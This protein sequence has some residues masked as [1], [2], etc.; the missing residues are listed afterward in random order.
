MKFLPL[1]ATLLLAISCN[2]KE[3]FYAVSQP[4][5]ATSAVN[6]PDDAPLIPPKNATV[7]GVCKIETAPNY[8]A[9]DKDGAVIL[10]PD[11][12]LCEKKVCMKE[13]NDTPF[14][15]VNP[16]KVVFGCQTLQS[17]KE[18]E[19]TLGWAADDASTVYIDGQMMGSS[20]NWTVFNEKTITL[21]GGCHTLA[22]HAVD[23]YQ[24]ISG[25]L[26]YMKIDGEIVWKSG[27]GNEFLKAYG[28]AAPQGEW[29]S[30]KY[31]E[32][33]WKNSESCADTSPWGQ[34]HASTYHLGSKWIWWSKNCRNLTQAF[35][36]LSFSLAAPQ[37]LVD[38]PN[39]CKN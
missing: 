10:I 38:D 8:D 32:S 24:V 36:R 23:V 16:A 35:F 20:N 29:Q 3:D 5:A 28:P 14:D 19:L 6:L 9:R 30:L 34:V 2:S 4:I 18:Y 39:L 26:A 7:R 1:L 11:N 12:S 17:D 25:I 33:A 13:H 15:L 22:I 21:K 27:D 37:K 31:D